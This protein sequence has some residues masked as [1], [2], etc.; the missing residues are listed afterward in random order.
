[1][2]L[3]QLEGFIT[4]RLANAGDTFQ[5][6]HSIVSEIGIPR[7]IHSLLKSVLSD[8]SEVEKI[9]SNSHTHHNG[10]DKFTLIS[11]AE[12]EYK[13]RLH[14]WWPGHRPESGEHI[15]DH[16]W[17]FSSAILTGGYRF[18]LFNLSQ[19]GEELFHYRCGF[20]DEGIG[21]KVKLLGR[22]RAK[23][24]FSCDLSSGCA[25]S[26]Q[27]TTL[28][29]INNSEKLTSTITLHQNFIRRTSNLLSAEPLATEGDIISVPFKPDAFRGK[30]ER[31]LEY[32]AGSDR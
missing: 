18:Q 20:P 7:K 21:Y 26:L 28:H 15:H 12:P 25:Y 23:C 10:F 14:I 24:Q 5:E 16:S 32:L 2:D 19:E 9:A 13:L 27:Y 30:I 29:R 8:P 11:S 6:T 22:A 31:Y 4:E 3:K 17:N 1:M